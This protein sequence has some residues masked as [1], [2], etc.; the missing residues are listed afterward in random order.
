M[1]MAQ[2]RKA[3]YEI[4]RGDYQGTNDNNAR[5]WYVQPINGPVDRRGRGYATRKAAENALLYI[6]FLESLIN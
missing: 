1:T 4:T 6:L 5:R 3:G 2:I